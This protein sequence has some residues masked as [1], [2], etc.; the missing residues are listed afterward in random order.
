MKIMWIN[1]LYTQPVMRLFLLS[2]KNLC[3]LSRHLK[4]GVWILK[5]KQKITAC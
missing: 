3:N 2:L 4:N 5:W 1:I